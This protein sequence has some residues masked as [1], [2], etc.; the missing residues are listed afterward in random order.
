[1]GG[2]CATYNNAAT[3]DG[4][5]LV[6]KLVQ[7]LAGI[8]FVDPYTINPLR[9]ELL[10]GDSRPSKAQSRNVCY[11]LHV[12]IAK[13]NKQFYSDRTKAFFEEINNPEEHPETH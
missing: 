2:K 13:Y 12:H 10:F 8:E 6:W 3:V 5:E 11:P 1:M 9:A 7:V 4:G